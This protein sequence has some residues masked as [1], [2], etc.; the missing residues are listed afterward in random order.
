MIARWAKAARGAQTASPGTLRAQRDHALR[1]RPHL[2]LFLHRAEERLRMPLTG[3]SPV[4]GA[5]GADWAWRPELWRAIWPRTAR[6]P[7]SSGTKIGTETSFYH[8]ARLAEITL[9]QAPN[10]RE[11]DLAPYRLDLDILGFD[12]GFL[13]LVLDLP[14]AGGDGLGR[15]HILQ[16][17]LSAELEAPLD[18]F[19][20]LNVQHGPNTEQMTLEAP[21]GVPEAVLEFDLAYS[22]VNEKRVEK[23]WIDLIFET[24][25]M[26]RI[27]LRDITVSRR[28][29]AAL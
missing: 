26:N 3:A 24:P 28:L 2:D 25:R 22:K 9:R 14:Q 23:A 29:R 10:L 20:R 27:S 7:L 8:D 1:L 11:T 21:R 19:V 5:V 15:G 13:S 6:A 18:T 17:S 12:G 16:V 4:G